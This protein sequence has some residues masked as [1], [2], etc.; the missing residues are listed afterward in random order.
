MRDIM[1]R[2]M[3]PPLKVYFFVYNILHWDKSND[4]IMDIDEYEKRLIRIDIFRAQVKSYFEILDAVFYNILNAN[5]FTIPDS[6]LSVAYVSLLKQINIFKMD[7]MLKT[8]PI[9]DF[10]DYSSLDVNIEAMV[11]NYPK[12][13]KEILTYRSLIENL[14]YD[15]CKMEGNLPE[16]IQSE[17]EYYNE[18]INIHRESRGII[19]YHEK[20]NDYTIRFTAHDSAKKR[21][22]MELENNINNWVTKKEIIKKARIKKDF[23]ARIY[24]LRR[25]IIKQDLIDKLSIVNNESKGSY[26]LSTLSS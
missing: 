14:F 4:Y 23:Y 21:I 1:I 3:E 17:I 25:D 15:I 24:Q 16:T 2:L 10:N 18:L 5:D 6:Y 9:F 26:K 12:K 13:R 19:N 7:D 20:T 11:E 8:L 22:Y